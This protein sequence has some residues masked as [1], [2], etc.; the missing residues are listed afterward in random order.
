MIPKKTIT[1]IIDK[2]DIVSLVRDYIKLQKRGANYIGLCP[3]H[4]EKTPSFS[5]SPQK[6][7]W[8]CFGCNQGGNI[9]GFISKIENIN[10]IDTMKFLA[11]NVGIS[12]NFEN[13]F[14]DKN[15]E[16][17]N[18]VGFAVDFY[19]Q[20]LFKPLATH[21]LN[22]LI[23]RGFTAE[24]LIDLRL[25][26]AP[27]KNALF[28]YLKSQ[29]VSIDNMISAGLVQ[30]RESGDVVDRF[31]DRVVF[32]I[33]NLSGDAIAF[34][35]RVLPSHTVIDKA[36]KY[37]NSPENDIYHKGRVLYGLNLTKEFVKKEGRLLLVEG[38]I[39]FISV[40][41]HGIRNSA[42]TLGT[43]LTTDQARL[44]KRFASEVVIGYDSD[45][46]GINAA[47]RA[48]DILLQMELK[49]SIVEYSHKDPDQVISVLGVD[50]LNEQIRQAKPYVMFRIDK[51][52]AK[53]NLSVPESV[54]QAANELIEFLL[55]IKANVIIDNYVKYI[56]KKLKITEESIYSRMKQA[57]YF[58]K[59]GK[60]LSPKV[61]TQPKK[62]K[63]LTAQQTVIRILASYPEYR[64]KLNGHITADC[65]TD[66]MLKNI[67][68]LLMSSNDTNQKLIDQMT[69]EHLKN[70]YVAIMIDD[71]NQ[72]E[73]NG[74]WDNINVLKQYPFELKLKNIE[75]NIKDA[76]EE[77]NHNKLEGLLKEYNELLISKS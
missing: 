65:F 66:M 77:N 25:G 6:K 43:A 16:L 72:E 51:I 26:Y 30:K 61:I 36:P 5:V 76:Q 21:A 58:R 27:R 47:M 70:R 24:Q 45:Q 42:A 48:A 17:I 69:D 75:M 22:Y 50:A 12:I 23:N 19:H 41:L 20:Q 46:A 18:A 56:A 2:T 15:L 49:V 57:K 7:I 40:Y 32:P 29:N 39:D 54:T 31:Q 14:V 35:G 73:V 28:N 8:H 53:Y 68:E 67:F 3:F 34:G 63:Y 59:R 9:V 52:V 13:N 38:Y 44:I 64:I 10:F 62:D 37:L 55:S 1:E 74:F 33:Q 71:N 4:S 11:S 60:D